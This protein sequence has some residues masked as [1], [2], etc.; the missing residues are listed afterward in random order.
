[1]NRPSF[2]DGWGY[3]QSYAP[4]T[5]RSLHSVPIFEAWAPELQVMASCNVGAPLAMAPTQVMTAAADS[6]S[7]MAMERATATAINTMRHLVKS[8]ELSCILNVV[9]Q[10]YYWE[11]K[12]P[13][14]LKG[15]S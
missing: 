7:G 9:H 4:R 11:T 1:M 12:L 15:H 13:T 14:T 8:S 3:H 5:L 6:R 10:E 2:L